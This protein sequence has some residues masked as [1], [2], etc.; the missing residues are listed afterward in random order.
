MAADKCLKHGEFM[1]GFNE[2]LKCCEGL[3][4]EAGPVAGVA[5]RCVK[6][7][8]CKAEGEGVGFH[9]GALPCCPGLEIKPA[10][11]YLIGSAGTCV[12]KKNLN[13]NDSMIN[14]KE[15]LPGLSKDPVSTSSGK[16]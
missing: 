6:K 15:T 1:S 8:T 10:P 4:V 14:S 2:G 9:P 12:K 11:A 3:D 5:S 16:Q 13:V 7:T